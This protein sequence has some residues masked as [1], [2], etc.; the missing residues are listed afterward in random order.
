MVPPNKQ[1]YS[2][3]KDRK[4]LCVYTWSLSRMCMPVGPCLY[5]WLIVPRGR[6]HTHAIFWISSEAVSSSKYR[7]WY[8]AE[9][10]VGDTKRE[11]HIYTLHNSTDKYR[12]YAAEFC[13][14]CKLEEMLCSPFSL[15]LCRSS[16]GLSWEDSWQMYTVNLGRTDLHRHETWNLL[17]PSQC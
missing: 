3:A 4:S 8:T 13:L 2:S 1:P 15:V 12:F 9:N 6:L 5:T 16:R 7:A 17:V 10:R 11:V 14:P